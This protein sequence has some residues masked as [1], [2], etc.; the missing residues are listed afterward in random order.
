MAILKPQLSHSLSSL[1]PILVIHG[2]ILV[3]LI[4]FFNQLD[5]GKLF[6]KH[7]K[8]SG[9]AAVFFVGTYMLTLFL[10][11]PRIRRL[12]TLTARIGA[13]MLLCL[14]IGV[15]IELIQ[16]S[17]G[18]ESSLEDV[19]YDLLGISAAILVYL[20]KQPNTGAKQRWQMG[21][22]ACLLLLISAAKPIY[23]GYLRIQQQQLLPILIDFDANWQN[24]L[25]VASQGGEV[26]IVGSPDGWLENQS[27]VL[28]ITMDS[29]QYP[30]ASLNHIW[31]DWSGYQSLSMDLYS[32]HSDSFPLVVRIHD[33][34]HNLDYDDRFNQRIIVQPGVNHITLDLELVKEAPKNRQMELNDISALML[35]TVRPG[36]PRQVFLDNIR[37]S[38]RDI[39]ASDP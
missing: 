5:T 13:L 36:K 24:I 32:A 6:S 28:Q 10:D 16:P 20:L 37:L 34:K 26:A 4:M 27:R 19:I 29:T 31:S 39:V 8:D 30:G 25:F 23:Y 33:G 12:G 3:L 21:T 38:G 7:L 22:A 35:F 2:I 9:H 11:S 1:L 18:R 17:F 15:A 14:V